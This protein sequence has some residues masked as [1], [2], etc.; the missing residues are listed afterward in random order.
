MAWIGV[1]PGLATGE[2]TTM[3]IPGIAITKQY[4]HVTSSFMM[5]EIL[6]PVTIVIQGLSVY[7]Q[8]LYEIQILQIKFYLMFVYTIF[9]T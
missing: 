2:M 1:G 5:M 3:G 8:W 6:V 4:S 7:H 9:R